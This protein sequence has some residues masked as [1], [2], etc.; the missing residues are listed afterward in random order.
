MTHR[1]ECLINFNILNRLVIV[2]NKVAFVA[3][4]FTTCSC[5]GFVQQNFFIFAAIVL[6]DSGHAH[7]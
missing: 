3:D 4:R 6:V 5:F 7:K 1:L 2:D